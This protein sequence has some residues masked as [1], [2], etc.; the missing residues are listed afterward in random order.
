MKRKPLF[1]TYVYPDY[2]SKGTSKKLNPFKLNE[3]NSNND[4]NSSNKMDIVDC[5]L[6]YVKKSCF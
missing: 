5:T 4:E 2:K 6:N 1:K 3:E